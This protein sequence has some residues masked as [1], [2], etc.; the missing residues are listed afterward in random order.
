MGDQ[1]NVLR[2]AAEVIIR[3]LGEKF[4]LVVGL[5]RSLSLKELQALASCEDRTDLIRRA[6]TQRT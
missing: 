5:D 2:D 6:L 1:E 4:E 3:P